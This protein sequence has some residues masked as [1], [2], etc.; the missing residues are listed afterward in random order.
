M[1]PTW[2][3][4]NAYDRLRASEWRNKDPASTRHHEF[5]YLVFVAFLQQSSDIISG[6]GGRADGVVPHVVDPPSHRL[7]R[8]KENS[9]LS[10]AVG[11]TNK[12]P[13]SHLSLPTLQTGPKIILTWIA[14]KED[15]LIW[16]NKIMQLFASFRPFHSDLTG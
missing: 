16:N 15:N 1:G 4:F 7:Q 10:H 13:E 14:Y 6:D 11:A 2:H 12:D 8:Q 5:P 3:L 9:H